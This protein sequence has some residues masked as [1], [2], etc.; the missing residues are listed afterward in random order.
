MNS[1]LIIWKAIMVIWA[2]C[3]AVNLFFANIPAA[4]NGGGCVYYCWVI[5]IMIKKKEKSQ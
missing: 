4:F 1:D 3:V 5:Y 2:L